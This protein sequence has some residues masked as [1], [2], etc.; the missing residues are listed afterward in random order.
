MKKIL[1]L[2]NIVSITFFCM[3]QANAML[4]SDIDAWQYINISSISSSTIHYNSDSR[5]MFGYIGGYADTISTVFNDDSSIGTWHQVEWTLNSEITLG[6]FNLVA[7][8]DGT[9]APYYRDQN[10]RGF[11]AFKLEYKDSADNWNVLYSKDHIGTTVTLSDGL[12]HYVYGGGATYKNLWNYEIY[13]TVTPATA[14]TWRISFQQFGEANGHASGPR[15]VE[16]DGYIYE[17]GGTPVPEPATMILFGAGIAGLVAVRRR[18][19][20]F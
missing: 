15:I 4:T 11:G 14:T 17:G 3:S 12:E 9:G 5:N 10:Y 7:A 6:S 18:K 19:K 1:Y 13:D 2:G 8:H 16:L 20:N